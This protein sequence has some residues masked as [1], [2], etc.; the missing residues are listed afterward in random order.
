MQRS[1]L[2]IRKRLEAIR[3]PTMPQV[4][5]KLMQQCQDENAGMSELAL[6]ISQDPGLA[7]TVL[8]AANSSAYHRNGG[9]KPSIEQALMTLGT[10]MVKTL[11]ISESVFQ[12]FNEFSRPGAI[13]LRGFWKHSLSAACLARALAQRIQHPHAEEAYLA[14]LL[15]DV[16]RL[17]LL[18]AAPQEYAV[19]FHAYDDAKLCWVE[20]RTLQ[21]NHAEAGAWLVGR[22]KLD[23]FLADSI[24]YHHEPT[25]RLLNAHPLI[26]IVTLAHLLSTPEANEEALADAGRLCELTVEELAGLRDRAASQVEKAASMLGIDLAGA[27]DIPA[28][29]A[30]VPPQS[31]AGQDVMQ[32]Q[33]GEEM[34]NMV[35]A[36]SIGRTLGR[37]TD[38]N[39]L[40]ETL[41]RSAS[42]LFGFD[43][44]VVL[45]TERQERRMRGIPGEGQPRRLAEFS[46]SLQPGGRLGDA[47]LNRRIAVIHRNGNLLDL[48]EEQLLGMLSSE[49]LVCLPLIENGE[50]VGMLIGSTGEA[51][52]AEL[53]ARERL[54]LTFGAQGAKALQ[55]M[56]NIAA[57]L[58]SRV[59]EVAQE[60]QAATR[61]VAH[62]VNNPLSIIKNYLGILDGKLRRQDMV[63]NEVSILHEE[64]D[65]VGQIV[66]ELANLQPAPSDA[67][68]EI[69]R[70]VRDVVKLFQETE[71]LPPKVNIHLMLQSAPSEVEASADTIKQILMNLLKNAVE[72]L[73]HGGDIEI[74]DHG[75]VNRDGK[76]YVELSLR[77][78]GPGMPQHVLAGLF[79]PV[80]ST[81]PGANRGLGLS[82]V[83]GLVSKLNGMILCR[84]N[85]GG[86]TFEILLPL[87]TRTDAPSAAAAAPDTL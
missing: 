45:L 37:Q 14:G 19:N 77:D 51:R 79:S 16:G 46:V 44:A 10:D 69:G 58:D 48:A 65:R 15:H 80:K 59:K 27:D 87:R 78:N 4:L 64:I 41:V 20:Q 31:A 39:G 35:L 81:K 3:L 73:P 43:Q 72:A 9:R 13:D 7:G 25:E 2:D 68:V 66:R 5:L 62:E 86:T 54:L 84:S 56:Q 1:E 11:V 60:Y 75:T 22:W 40:L 29:A 57:E 52:A 71:F 26:R 47:A 61:R 49:C 76:L 67:G 63:V 32:D 82:I 85:G 74:A 42:I 55:Q 36:T 30:Y 50:C 12:M 21:M 34:R 83:H 70:V 23:S 53:Q 8:T 18:A 17:A 28:Q 6:L 24:Q 38:Q 33:F